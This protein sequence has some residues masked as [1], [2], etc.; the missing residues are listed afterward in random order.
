MD[1]GKGAVILQNVTSYD[2]QG[3]KVCFNQ[4]SIYA[5]GAGGF[6]GK[7]NSDK[8]MPL[9]RTPSRMPDASLKEKTGVTQAALYRLNGDY[10]P[11]HIDPAFAQMGG[12]VQCTIESLAQTFLIHGYQMEV[13]ISEL[14]SVSRNNMNGS[15][16]LLTSVT[17]VS[18]TSMHG[19]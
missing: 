1:K 11:L 17:S 7:R 16:P 9:G 12:T 14:S 3:E 10:N 6:G 15:Q 4:F 19:H 5:G 2:E 8:V 18:N 13:T